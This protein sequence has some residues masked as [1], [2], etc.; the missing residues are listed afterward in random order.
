MPSRPRLPP[1]ATLTELG[2]VPRHGVV[3]LAP[4]QCGG[5]GAPVALPVRGRSHRAAATA[6]A[7]GSL[8]GVRLATR[9]A[10]AQPARLLAPRPALPPRGA[11]PGAVTDT[12]LREAPPTGAAGPRGRARPD[13]AQGP[14]GGRRLA[15]PLFHLGRGRDVI[16]EGAGGLGFLARVDTPM[17]VGWGFL[18]SQRLFCQDVPELLFVCVWF[19]L[20][21]AGVVCGLI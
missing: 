9:P 6:Q 2:D 10:P 14:L 4:V 5:R 18:T 3:L 15:P 17:A 11:G 21:R 20:I 16:Q 13:L 8:C 7:L 19:D 1:Q 12:A